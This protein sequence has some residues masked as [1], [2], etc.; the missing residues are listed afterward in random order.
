[1]Q[2][3][4]K[5]NPRK[6]SSASTLSGSIQRDMSKVIISFPTNAD[7]IAL[8][9]KTLI[10]D[11][12]VVNTKVGFDSNIFIK[13]KQKKLVYK[14]RNKETD[15]IENKRDSTVILKIDENNQYENAMT[16]PLP[17]SCIKKE[18]CTPN[19]CKLSLLLS[20]ISHKDG[21]GHL[22]VVAREFNVQKATEK[23][24]LFEK[25]KVVPARDRSAFQ[26]FDAIRLR[27]NDILN[28]Y[29]CAAKTHSTMDKKY[30]IPLYAEHLKFLL[31]RCSWTI[32]KIH[33]S[34]V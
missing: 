16:K 34:S 4:F 27:Q 25:Q 12:S 13:D 6:C 3:K 7:V 30:L 17:I 22:L 8:M 31:Q 5:F 9:E 32:T 14:I 19:I 2:E 15:E 29:K 28:N 23:Q 1:M 11:M 24:L 10:G 18:V 33:N 21:M 26:L 20:G